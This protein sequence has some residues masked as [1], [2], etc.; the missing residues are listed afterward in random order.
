MTPS[1]LKK[2]DD[3]YFEANSIKQLIESEKIILKAI[4]AFPDQTHL[5][6][7]LARNKFRTGKRTE[8]KKQKLSLFEDCLNTAKKGISINKN[9]A[10]NIYYMGLCLGNISLQKGILSSLRNRETL[11][12]EM[13][14]ALTI[15]PAIEHAGPHRFLG[16]YYSVLPFFLGGDSKKAINHLQ[17]A[18]KLAPHFAENY[19]YLGKVY[20]DK[21][22]D[23]QALNILERF[24]H[25][26]KTVKNDPE[27]PKQINEALEIIT[28]IKSDQN[29]G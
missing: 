3:A 19:F 8:D 24:L 12:N 14:R 23:S 20:Y 13:E 9:S 6:W 2:I 21:G 11:K 10:E 18:V 29:N 16:V 7:R 1:T 27:M 28:R 25:L 17:S 5:I 22:Y 15:N 4:E 26:A